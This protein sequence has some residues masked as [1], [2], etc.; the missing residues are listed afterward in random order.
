MSLDV[1]EGEIVGLIGPNGAGK[2]TLFN[3]VS[4]LVPPATGRIRLFDRDVTDVPVHARAALGVARTFQII[5]LF[6]ELTVFENLLAA[7]HLRNGT[8]AA[9]HVF[10]TK[11]ALQHEEAAR[12]RVRQVVEELE[13]GDIADRPVAGLPFGILR[14]I[15]VARALVTEAPVIMLDEPASGLDNRETDRLAQLLLSIR[16]ERGVSMLLIEHDVR[17]VT[18]VSDY[19]YVIDRGR[20]LAEGTPRDVQRDPRVIAAYLGAE[21]APTEEHEASAIPLPR[22]RKGPPAGLAA[23]AITSALR[24]R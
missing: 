14:M 8:G 12:K 20:P 24:L 6:S 17:L 15:E 18:W 5:Q 19:M 22:P 2:T 7:T 9:S 10:V 3:A 21:A 4:G 11:G 16:A 13:L 1:R 23:A